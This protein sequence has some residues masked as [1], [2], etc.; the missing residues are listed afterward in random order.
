MDG[1]DCLTRRLPPGLPV[2][3]T[4]RVPINNLVYPVFGYVVVFYSSHGKKSP[5]ETVPHNNNTKEADTV[6]SMLKPLLSL[7]WAKTVLL[8]EGQ[9]CTAVLL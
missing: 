6:V 8:L 1:H 9:R 4:I 3:T 7:C 5:R 2:D